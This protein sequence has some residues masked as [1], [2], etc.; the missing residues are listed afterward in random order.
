VFQRSLE[1]HARVETRAAIH[2]PVKS[3]DF[4]QFGSKGARGILRSLE[5]PLRALRQGQGPPGFTGHIPF[6]RQVQ[7]AVGRPRNRS[8]DGL[9]QRVA[10]PGIGM[11][12]LQLQR[13]ASYRSLG[14]IVARSG[15]GQPL[16]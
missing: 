15:S 6:N 10:E 1:F 7:I 13:Q 2:Q 5:P 11:L 3:I 9:T 8:P 16:V 14:K 12:P 4:L